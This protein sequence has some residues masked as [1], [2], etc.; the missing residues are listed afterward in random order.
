MLR[1]L[2]SFEWVAAQTFHIL[3]LNNLDGCRQQTLQS[4]ILILSY[5]DWTSWFCV[6]IGPL[7]LFYDEETLSLFIQDED[8]LSQIWRIGNANFFLLRKGYWENQ[9]V[10]I[11]NGEQK[12]NN[13]WNL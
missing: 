6:Q 8:D 10:F 3:G 7:S 1:L 2:L 4:L 13:K 12:S 5:F 11:I 9:K